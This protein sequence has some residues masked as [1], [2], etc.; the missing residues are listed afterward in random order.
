MQSNEPV[1]VFGRRLQDRVILFLYICRVGNPCD[2]MTRYTEFINSLGSYPER[3]AKRATSVCSV[4]NPR[5]QNDKIHEV[6]FCFLAP[7]KKGFYLYLYLCKV[8]GKS[9]FSDGEIWSDSRE[10]WED[11]FEGCV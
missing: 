9:G 8:H 5:D 7:H 2:Q 3:P 11:V 1:R 4:G 6:C 10:H